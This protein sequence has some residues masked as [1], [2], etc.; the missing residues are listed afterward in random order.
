MDFIVSLFPSVYHIL[1]SVFS[2]FLMQSVG[3]DD[4]VFL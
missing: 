3:A 1:L 4:I 2:S